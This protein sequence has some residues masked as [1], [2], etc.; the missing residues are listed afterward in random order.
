MLNMVLTRCINP[1]FILKPF[2]NCIKKMKS[3]SSQK[4]KAYRRLQWMKHS[5]QVLDEKYSEGLR[6]DED[7]TISESTVTCTLECLRTLS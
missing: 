5:N 7:S 4:D 6:A 3:V 2:Q 1:L